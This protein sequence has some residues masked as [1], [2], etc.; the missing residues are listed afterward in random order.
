[1][2]DHGSRDAAVDRPDASPDAER[3]PE[4][5]VIGVFTSL[6][7][8]Q[9]AVT[10]LAKAGFDV[11]RLSLIGKDYGTEERPVGIPR[12]TVVGYEAEL[13]AGRFLVIVHDT[14]YRAGREAEWL[15]LGEGAVSV[16]R[17]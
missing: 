11:R 10:S 3:P 13:R 2:M 5:A 15:L 1:M 4:P 14:D 12:D 8:A 16:E 17:S 7:A 6:H 9:S